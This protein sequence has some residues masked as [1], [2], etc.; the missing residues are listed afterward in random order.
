MDQ[1]GVN[2]VEGGESVLG[3]RLWWWW[4]KAGEAI[5]AWPRERTRIDWSRVEA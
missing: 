2:F 5:E 4:G 1:D 3:G